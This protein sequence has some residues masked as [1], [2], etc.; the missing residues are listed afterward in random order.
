MR[1]QRIHKKQR[2]GVE[3]VTSRCYGAI[4][5]HTLFTEY[6][7]RAATEAQSCIT[8]EQHSSTTKGTSYIEGR[9]GEERGEGGERGGRKGEKG[10]E[11]RE[12]EE[13][14]VR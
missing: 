10:R 5:L 12:R 14:E 11:R 6:C 9:K 8:A 2:D 1:R 3:P 4:P 13:R 7:R